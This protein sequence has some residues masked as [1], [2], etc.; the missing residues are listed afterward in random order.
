MS[1]REKDSDGFF[2]LKK[3]EFDCFNYYYGSVNKYR[4]RVIGGPKVI[5]YY[6][7]NKKKTSMKILTQSD[8][9]WVDR[10]VELCNNSSVGG[11]CCVGW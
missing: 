6:K 1:I 10:I 9:E 11:V 7:V 3:G 4:P 5:K 8:R 2:I